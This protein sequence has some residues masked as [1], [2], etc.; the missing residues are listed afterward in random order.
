[1]RTLVSRLGSDDNNHYT[2]SAVDRDSEPP[3]GGDR[4]VMLFF[5]LDLAYVPNIYAVYSKIS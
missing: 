1:M 4:T 5:I 3:G 2:N